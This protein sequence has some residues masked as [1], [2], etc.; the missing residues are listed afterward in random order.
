MTRTERFLLQRKTYLG[1]GN[2]RR[3][4]ELLGVMSQAPFQRAL[5]FS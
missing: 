5:P 2:L 1:Q 3:Y 4:G